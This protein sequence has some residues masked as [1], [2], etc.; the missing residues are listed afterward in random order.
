MALSSCLFAK[1]MI[2]PLQRRILQLPPRYMMPLARNSN[3]LET[4]PHFE[5]QG[6]VAAFNGV[7][8]LQ[9]RNYIKLS[10]SS[11]LHR[12]LTSHNWETPSELEFKLGS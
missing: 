5:Q 11:Y 3:F 4:S 1:S 9:T 10:C 8:V 7:D 6:L 2:L 12:L